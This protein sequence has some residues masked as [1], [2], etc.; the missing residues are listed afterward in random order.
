MLFSLFCIL[1]LV[2]TFLGAFFRGPGYAWSLP[3]VSGLYFVL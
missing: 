2:L 1:G 3:W